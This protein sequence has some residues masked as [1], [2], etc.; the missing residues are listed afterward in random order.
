MMLHRG[1]I[2]A[3]FALALGALLSS[4]AV[5]ALAAPQDQPA[6]AATD[7]NAEQGEEIIVTGQRE[8]ERRAIDAKRSSLTIED[9]VAAT[10]VGKL[11]DQNVAEAVRRLPGISIANDQGEGRYVVIRGVDPNLANVTLNGQT[12]AAPE[13]DGRQVKLDDIPSSLIGSVEVVKS[14]TADRDANAIAGQVDINTLSAF[15]KKGT[16]LFGRAAAGLPDLNDKIQ[17]EGD[18]TLG[19]RIG[20]FGVVLSGNASRRPIASENLQGSAAWNATS[21]LPDDYRVRR[22]NLVRERRGAVANI[23]YRPSDAVQ[24]FVRGIYSSFQDHETRDQFR[25]ALGNLATPPVNNVASFSGVRG[26]H[27]VRTRNEDDSTVTFQGGGKFDLGF[28]KL[29]LESTWSKAIKKDPLRSEFQ[30]RTG[31]GASGLAG[32]VDI[33][34]FL[35]TVDPTG[36]SGRWLDPSYYSALQVNYDRRRAEEK[37]K[38]FRADFEVPLSALSE[39]S[40]IKVGVKYLGRDKTNNRDYQQYDLNGFTMATAGI[41]IDEGTTIYDGLFRLG[42]RVDYAAAQAYITA[43][44]ARAV[45]NA[46]GSLGNSLVNDYIVSEDILAGYAMATLKF[47]NVTV[48]PGVRVEDT[49]GT[50]QGKTI[51]ATSTVSQG[52]NVKGKKDYTNVFPGLNVRF[53][54]SDRLVIRAG[55]TTAIG[56]PNYDDLAPFVQVDAGANTVAQ[57]NPTLKALRSQNADLSAEYYLPGHGLFSVAG[58]YKHIDDPI[59]SSIAITSGTFGGVALTNANVTQP[60]NANKSTV[61]GVEFNLQTPLTILWSGLDGFGVN[62]NYTRTGGSS[63][64]VPGRVGKVDNYLQSRDVASAQLYFEQGSVALRLAYSY[65]SHML[66]TVGADAAHD[67]YT[68]SNGQLDARASFAV[69]KQAI[70]FVEGSNLTDA[71]W[72]RYTGTPNHLAEQERYSYTLRAGLQLAF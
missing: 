68:D 40:S 43:N 45:L 32:T 4:A 7:D 19:G 2:R 63:S 42:P 3:P 29:S 17:W 71:K 52:F 72:R 56:R 23:D 51:T 33:S 5:P 48:I 47:G 16:F 67:Q 26:T 61:Y 55:A 58:F 1:R 57:G 35:F 24:I 14:L 36:G 38:Q 9:V 6:A 25:I 27:F 44:P 41:G 65:R 69:I 34:N 30:F 18:A 53:D 50:Y 15:D 62:L 10:D 20:D 21:G 39:D 64:G 8:A 54:A 66:D 28:G 60:I 46:S 13:P 12:A 70:V 31:S 49:S 11:P 37:L 59:F 22:Y